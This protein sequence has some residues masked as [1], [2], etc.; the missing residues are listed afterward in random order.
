MDLKCPYCNHEYDHD[1]NFEGMDNNNQLSEYCPKCNMSFTTCV[2]FLPCYSECRKDPCGNDEPCEWEV[3][4]CYQY[5]D[6]HII[7]TC[8]YCDNRRSSLGSPKNLD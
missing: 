5:G 2:Y 1:G 8:K 7:Y 3:K 4:N 6:T